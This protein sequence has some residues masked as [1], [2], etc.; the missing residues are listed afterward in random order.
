MRSRV[1]PQALYIL[2]AYVA[3]CMCDPIWIS[4]EDLKASKLCPAS[5][6]SCIHQHFLPL[7]C[8]IS[9]AD[10]FL[11]RNFSGRIISYIKSPLIDL[12]H[13][14]HIWPVDI[15]IYLVLANIGS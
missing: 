12:I 11:A 2:K 15:H 9:M 5:Q 4:L 3:S 14:V 7:S 10:L 13:Y 6:S 1:N 8:H